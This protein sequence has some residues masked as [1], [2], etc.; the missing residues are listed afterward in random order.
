MGEK[1]NKEVKLNW[2][3]WGTKLL[4]SNGRGKREES[5]ILP[6]FLPGGNTTVDEGI[7]LFIEVVQ[8]TDEDSQNAIF[9][10]P[11]GLMGLGIGLQQLPTPWKTGHPPNGVV[12]PKH[13]TNPAGL[14]A[15]LQIN[16][17]FTETS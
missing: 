11:S 6:A 4:F 16:C 10:I 14:S 17:Q 9:A 8:L 2:L 1:G 3:D 15:D 5:S 13:L 7:F 12:L